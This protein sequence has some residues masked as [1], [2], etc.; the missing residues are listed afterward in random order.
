[1]SQ[2]GKRDNITLVNNLTVVNGSTTV[3]SAGTDFDSNVD[4]GDTIV[5]A[6]VPYKVFSVDSSNTLTLDVGYEGSNT[7]S[8]SA[9]IQQSPKNL[10]TFGWGAN[11]TLGANT[12]NARNVYGIDRVEIN[13]P[14]NKGR[15]IGHTG[16]VHHT[17]YVNTQGT[18]RNHSEVLVAMSKNFNAN[19]TGVLN[20]ADAADDAVAVDYYLVVNTQPSN[21]SN[22]AGNAVVFTAAAASIPSGASLS[23]QWFESTDGETFAAVNDGGDYSGN[24]TASLT[25]ANVSNVDGNSFR[26]TV[27]TSET[28]VDSVNSDTAIATEL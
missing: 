23:Y 3:V 25:I 4:A 14:E 8:A 24:T 15:G 12:V 13:A 10:S 7:S 11:A 2:W 6:T 20:F 27:S 1:M 17:S 19:A 16:W 21:A 26:V 9:S 22:T 5:I 28:G 18:T